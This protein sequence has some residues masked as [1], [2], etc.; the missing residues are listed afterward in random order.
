MLINTYHPFFSIIF[1]YT[2]LPV[3]T[4][5]I[6]IVESLIDNYNNIR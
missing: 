1:E 2:L 3:L 5:H 4:F 6:L